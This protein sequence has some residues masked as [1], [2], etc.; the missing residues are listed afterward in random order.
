[1]TE[2]LSDLVGLPESLQ[3][4]EQSSMMKEEAPSRDESEREK[5]SRC[6]ELQNISVEQS[7]PKS[8]LP[9]NRSHP[10]VLHQQQIGSI[11][12]TSS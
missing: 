1:M 3:D 5:S 12:R 7:V 2:R 9:M 11:W 6:A 8:P 10:S 4:N